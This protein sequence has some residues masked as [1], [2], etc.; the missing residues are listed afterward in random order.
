MLALKNSIQSSSLTNTGNNLCEF[1]KESI[2]FENPI[3]YIANLNLFYTFPI[4]YVFM[5]NVK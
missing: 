1:Y 4:I 2:I 3:T 5:D